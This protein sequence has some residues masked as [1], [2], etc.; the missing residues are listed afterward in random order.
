MIQLLIIELQKD[1]GISITSFLKG[2]D[3]ICEIAGDFNTALEK[4]ALVNYDCILLDSTL[5]G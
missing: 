5:L 3:Y 4:T 2:Q 1:L